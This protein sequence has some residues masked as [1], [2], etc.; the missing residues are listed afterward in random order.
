MPT[1]Q[2]E[3]QQFHLAR[4]LYR[5]VFEHT[6]SFE[7]EDRLGPDLAYLLGAILFGITCEWPPDRPIVVLLRQHLPPDDP[8]WQHITLEPPEA[9]A[10][11][12]RAGS[13]DSPGSE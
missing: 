7:E 13:P 6:G 5:T 12:A 10:P 2:Q 11:S 3:A 1:L 9:T 8:L 4:R